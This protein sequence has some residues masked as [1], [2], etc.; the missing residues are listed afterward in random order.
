[1]MASM[2][3]PMYDLP[4]HFPMPINAAGQGPEMDESRVVRTICWS[5]IPAE[6]WP[7]KASQ[8]QEPDSG[9]GKTVRL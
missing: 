5:C 3:T 6:D 4:R 8:W 7:C 2:S 9:P 1:M